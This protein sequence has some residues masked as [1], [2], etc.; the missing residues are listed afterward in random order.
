M[1]FCVAINSEIKAASCPLRKGQCYWQ[2]QET[3]NCKYTEEELSV[4][5]FCERTGKTVPTQEEHQQL[6]ANLKH[7]L[8]QP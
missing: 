8:H 5:A 4:E 1:S 2:H 6:V 7:A 3:N